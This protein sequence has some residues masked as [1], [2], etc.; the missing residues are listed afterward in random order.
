[1]KVQVISHNKNEC[2]RETKYDIM[3]LKRNIDPNLHPF[4]KQR[5]YTRSLNA[6]KLERLYAKP[7]IT[8]LDKH[9]DAIS[10]LAKTM[11]L[12]LVLAGTA[13]GSITLWD[14]AQR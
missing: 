9:S 2:T 14:I 11:A 6:T 1:M 13:D 12:P 4:E 3:K 8:A 10:T 5:E 7:F